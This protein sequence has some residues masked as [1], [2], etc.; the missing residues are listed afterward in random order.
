MQNQLRMFTSPN[1]D[2]PLVITRGIL[3][4]SLRKDPMCQLHRVVVGNQV[5]MRPSFQFNNR[6]QAPNEMKGKTHQNTN[7]VGFP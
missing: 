7:H 4:L 2:A 3:W 5:N 6:Y 1:K